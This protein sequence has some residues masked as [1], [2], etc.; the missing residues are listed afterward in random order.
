MVAEQLPLLGHNTPQERKKRGA[1]LGHIVAPV[2]TLQLFGLHPDAAVFRIQEPWIGA[3]EHF[4]PPQAVGND[5]DDGTRLLLG[6]G[7]PV[8]R[9]DARRS[10]GEQQYGECGGN[11][12]NPFGHS[13]PCL[14]ADEYSI[15]HQRAGIRRAADQPPGSI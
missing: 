8:C 9:G 5:Q 4:L 11:P 12:P 7:Y 14:S 13:R 1:A 10:D 2:G 3:G 15:V 6:C